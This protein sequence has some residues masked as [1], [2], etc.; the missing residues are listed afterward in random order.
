MIVEA[1]KMATPFRRW[2]LFYFSEW[3]K[4]VYINDIRF[5]ALRKPHVKQWIPK[6]EIISRLQS[7]DK[8]G[9]HPSKEKN[10]IKLHSSSNLGPLKPLVNTMYTVRRIWF[11]SRHRT[12]TQFVIP[13]HQLLRFTWDREYCHEEMCHSVVSSNL[14]YFLPYWK[15]YRNCCG[16]KAYDSIQLVRKNHTSLHVV[17]SVGICAKS[18]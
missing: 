10:C 12:S 9:N 14:S 4:L 7:T 3:Q 8:H 13:Y 1:E 2:Q 15:E 6:Q 16:E 17:Y 11:R 5:P 18:Y